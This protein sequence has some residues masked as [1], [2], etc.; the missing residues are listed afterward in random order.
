MRSVAAVTAI[1]CG[2]VGV[3]NNRTNDVR[4]VSTY[5]NYDKEASGLKRNHVVKRHN[6]ARSKWGKLYDFSQGI[7]CTITIQRGYTVECFTENLSDVTEH[8]GRV[9]MSW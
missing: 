8:D 3:K 9:I 4:F 2:G 1:R 5:E 7:P 6:L